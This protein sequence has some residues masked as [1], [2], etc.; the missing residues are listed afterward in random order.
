M[1]NIVIEAGKLATVP[2][3]NIYAALYF[4]YI[5]LMK[6]PAFILLCVLN[7]YLFETITLPANCPALKKTIVA[8]KCMIKHGLCA[9]SSKPCSRNKAGNT[10]KCNDC[11]VFSLWTHRAKNE[12]PNLL[13]SFSNDY[14]LLPIPT[15]TTYIKKQWKPPNSITIS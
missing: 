4:M 2:P 3:H 12:E 1:R 11:I 5:Y 7:I 14:A 6:W 10:S 8:K 13:L 15:V 9:H